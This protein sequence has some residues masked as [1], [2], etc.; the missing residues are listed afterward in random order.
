MN[1]KAKRE[2]DQ[3]GLLFSF[4]EIVSE[5]LGSMLNKYKNW[6]NWPSL[7]RTHPS[8]CVGEAFQFFGKLILRCQ[9]LLSLHLKQIWKKATSTFETNLKL[10]SCGDVGDEDDNESDKEEDQVF[11]NH[12]EDKLWQG[13]GFKFY[14]GNTFNPMMI[15]YSKVKSYSQLKAKSQA[16]I[17]VRIVFTCSHDLTNRDPV[18]E[19]HAYPMDWII[20]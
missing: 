9:Q 16:L 13:L 6:R 1:M 17:K 19:N 10:D 12:D 4:L 5:E 2:K 14:T 7:Y 8:S 18:G 11:K 3:W 20:V 15:Q